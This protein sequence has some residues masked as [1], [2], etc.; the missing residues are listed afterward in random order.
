LRPVA[1]LAAALVACGGAT[2]TS[3]GA[4]PG[5]P[6]AGPLVLDDAGVPV[7][8]HRLLERA[9]TLGPGEEAYWC[10]SVV[11]AED[12]RIGGFSPIA[13]L[14]THHTVVSLGSQVPE[15]P[16]D[17]IDTGAIWLYASGV[18]TGALELP[19]GVGIT[20]HAGT[21]VNLQLHLFNTLDGPLTGTSGVAIRPLAPDDVD[22]E[23]GLFMP[24]PLDLIIPPGEH[25][26]TGNC[27]IQKPQRLF[28]LMP[29]LHQLGTHMKVELVRDGQAT[30]VL[31]DA[32]Y[33]F[34]SQAMTRVGPFD[35]VRGDVLRTTCTW[36]NPGPSTIRW[37][38]SS[39][40]EMCFAIFLRTPPD[41]STPVPALGPVCS[42]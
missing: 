32:P 16:C 22:Q 5:D 10:T 18:N 38:Q 11:L 30:Q 14:G 23:A 7:G 24:G 1:L 33:D 20:V 28:A 36:D 27:N 26:I 3:D 34:E 42:N 29:H 9:W 12:V 2:G 25:S 8:W 19:G 40:A 37:G 41:A 13:P 35:L 21:R 4:P 17:G 39:T 6:D 15:G 31:W